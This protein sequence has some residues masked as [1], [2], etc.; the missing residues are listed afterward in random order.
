MAKEY[1]NDIKIDDDLY[2]RQIIFL[3]METM[4]K[5]S[6]LRI[7][8]IG[9]RGLGVEI[10]KNIIVSGPQ[11]VI[12]F[13]PNEVKIEDLG[14]NFY[15]SIND[16]GK[17]RDKSCLTKLRKLN[18]YVIVDYIKEIDKIKNIED[19]K[20]NIIEN[21]NVIIISEILSKKNIIFLDNISR[22]NNIIL[23]YSSICGL[24]SFIFTDFGPKFTIYDEFCLRKRNFY[25]KNIERSEKGLVKIDWNKEQNPNISEYVIFKDVEGMT[26]IN[27]NEN[28]SKIFKIEP[29]SKDE[30][31]IGN[32]LNYSE[33]K[34]GG[35]VEETVLPKKVSYESF[36]KRLEEPFINKK[37]YINHK[38]KFIFIVLKAIM[39][40]Y[41]SKERLPVKNNEKDYEEIKNITKTIFDNLNY[42]NSKSFEKEEI[43]FDEKIVK[44][45]CYTCSAQIPCIT[46][47]I[48]GIVCQEII[49]TTGKF[50]PINQFKI[51]DFLQ[52]SSLIPE[53]NKNNEFESKTRYDDLITVF[54]INVVE[55]I[56][57]LNILLAGVGAVGSEILKILALFGITNSVLIVD[58]D[59]IEISNLNR[60]ILFHKEHKGLSKAKVSCESAREINSELNCNYINRRISQKNKDIFNK[61]YFSNV[62]FVFG[63][64]DSQE[65][66]YYLSKQCELFEKIFIKGGTK[67]AAGK[68]EAFI[69]NMTCSFNDIVFIEEKEDKL[70]SCTRR[71]FPRKIEDCIDTARDLF[72]EYFITSI[73]DFKDFMFSEIKTN[74]D[75][76]DLDI[77]VSTKRFN[78][79]NKLLCL[80]KYE[81]KI[82]IEEAL[83]Y[84]I[85][86]E[87]YQLFIKEIKDIYKYHPMN[88][89][90]ESKTF[91]NGKRIPSELKFDLHND[92]CK[93][94]LFSFLKIYADVLNLEVQIT[95]DIDIFNKKLNDL[96]V[97][98]L[99]NT[100]SFQEIIDKNAITNPEILYNKIK[101]IKAE[102]KND[103][104]IYQK[105]K[106]I[107]KI[108]FEKDNPEVCHIQFIYSLANL[109]AKVYKIP[110]C[111]KYYILEYVGKIA[112]TTITSTAVVAGF[113]CLQMIGLVINKMLNFAQ[114]KD[115]LN[116]YDE[117]DDEEL[118]DN[119]LH[120]LSFNLK[121]NFFVLEPL[122]DQS[123]KGI[124][125]IGG[126]IPEKFSRWYKIIEKGNKTVEE[127]N[128]NIK[129]KYGVDV[130][131]IL[132]A[133]DDRIIFQT[134]NKNKFNKKLQNKL[135]E[136]ERIKKLKIED[137][138]YE[139]AQK[140][141]KNYN[142]NND[143]FL[144]IKGFF[145]NDYIQFPVV[146]LQN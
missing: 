109:K 119:R 95:K 102:I 83:I 38:K 52:Y 26:E 40:F 56:R 88:D 94:F 32:T 140:I 11:K 105:I 3:G 78:Y 80:I 144:K 69:P 128:N 142:R 39:E 5:I 12:V 143:I 46:S 117:I 138:Y 55:K 48:G 129:E 62:D 111:D 75:K 131:L 45:I 18:E 43:H 14:S 116:E 100:N 27:Y 110:C 84:L 67:G 36:E 51:F 24:T 127:F 82:K 41:D 21:F 134:I 120:N 6:Q 113:M 23:I 121:N 50:I 65:G 125:K 77:N 1:S 60:Q 28:N 76:N 96:L 107:K 89:T 59:N 146:K 90:D 44:N 139:T 42:E 132:S 47:L 137:I 54:G 61:D 72:D 97:D 101:S 30:F 13:D 22:E 133:E 91:W 25:L 33:Y 73:S 10:A 92:L 104:N 81:D 123:F 64:I 8:I 130:T 106:K 20:E 34:S 4:K 19:I 9:L 108:N 112:P 71:Q 145:E 126:L 58:D 53:T 74:Y 118:I 87:Y 103:N 135:D 93:K 29:K 17:R 70:P 114:N 7:L 35:Y 31:Y 49:K 122:Y 68:T 141:C 79:Y 16:L 85:I 136:I 115:D 99:D 37:D 98:N 15:L 124:W 66:N 57:N 63:A 86:E 2:S